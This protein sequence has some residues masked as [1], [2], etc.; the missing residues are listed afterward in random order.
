MANHR[1]RSVGDAPVMADFARLA[2]VCAEPGKINVTSAVEDPNVRFTMAL[3][4]PGKRAIIAVFTA[5]LST[6]LNAL[7]N[8]T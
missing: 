7:A 2:W 6:A 1:L 5:A 4:A 8:V 3:L